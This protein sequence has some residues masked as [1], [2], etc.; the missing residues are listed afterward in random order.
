MGV[1]TTLDVTPSGMIRVST[2]EA[3]ET[4]VTTVVPS[5]A[6]DEREHLVWCDE[7]DEADIIAN[8]VPCRRK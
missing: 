8:L 4:K 7:E 6:R 2:L 3:L 5:W 1:Q